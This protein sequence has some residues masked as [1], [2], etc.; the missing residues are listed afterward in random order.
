MNFALRRSICLIR[1]RVVARWPVMRISRNQGGYLNL[2]AIVAGK[3][4]D[5]TRLS[6]NHNLHLRYFLIVA[7]CDRLFIQTQTGSTKRICV[8]DEHTRVERWTSVPFRM[9]QWGCETPTIRLNT[10]T[11]VKHH[12]DYF[13][14]HFPKRSKQD[15][16]AD[17]AVSSR[18]N[19]MYTS[20]AKPKKTVRGSFLQIQLAPNRIFAWIVTLILA[21][22]LEEAQSNIQKWQSY[23]P[24]FC[25]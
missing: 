15:E 5:R 4:F 25:M 3:S 11:L 16:L 10:S 17:G 6:T 13:V 19:R 21:W 1:Y 9:S 22:H 20:K 14:S 2:I 24:H 7:I 18:K 23:T 12:W 8:H